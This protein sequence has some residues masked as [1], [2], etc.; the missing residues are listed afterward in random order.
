MTSRIE[1]THAT[2]NPIT[3]CSKVSAG[4]VNCYAE[5]MAR[6]LQGMGTPKYRD[7][8]KVTLHPKTLHEPLTWKKPR[9]V[10]ANSMSDIFHPEVPLEYIQRIFATMYQASQHVFQLLTKRSERMLELAPRLPWPDNVW[11]GV[12]VEQASL[13]YRID[14]LRQT[15]AYGK[16]LSLEPLLGPLPDLNLTGIDWA[17]VGGESGPGAR[18]IEEAWVL[19]LQRQCHDRGVAFFFK[20]WGGANRRKTGRRLRGRLYEELPDRLFGTHPQI[21]LAL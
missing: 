10:F 7:G 3:G 18:P 4:C 2:W 17:I 16:F 21:S 20:Q 19:D 12:T 15:D 11:M 5:R 1:W 6:R 14:H 13:T 8:F 9:L